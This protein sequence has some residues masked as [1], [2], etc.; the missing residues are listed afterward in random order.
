[1]RYISTRGQVPEASENAVSFSQAIRAGYAPDGG[2]YVPATFPFPKSASSTTTTTGATTT[3]QMKYLLSTDTLQQWS[4][5]GFVALCAAVMRLWVSEEE[6]PTSDLNKA[7]ARAFQD[8]T[9][10]EVVK[11]RHF[12]AENNGKSNGEQASSGD[13][14]QPE[15]AT[16]SDNDGINVTAEADT[17]SATDDG[18]FV[19]ELFHGPTLAFKDFGRQ[20]S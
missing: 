9:E 2:L 18:I 4:S 8:F 11:V 16:D 5:L 6:L 10:P 20:V 3:N 17:H 7:V 14:Q 19:A 15:K 13:I 1:M 12:R